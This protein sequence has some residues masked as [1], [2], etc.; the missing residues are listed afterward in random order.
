MISARSSS[1]VWR[2]VFELGFATGQPLLV[3]V[4]LAEAALEPLLALIGPLL[5][6]RDLGAALAHLG[7]G[8]IAPPCRLFLC[9]EQHRLRLLLDGADLLETAFGIRIVA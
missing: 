4:E 7:L 5:Q 2:S 8:F 1:T 3:G 9:G 6:P